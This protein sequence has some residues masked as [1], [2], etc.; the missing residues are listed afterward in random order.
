MTAFYLHKNDV[1]RGTILANLITFLGRLPDTKAWKVEI[2]EHKKSRSPKQRR[3]LFGAAYKPIME[4]MGL[5][6]EEEKEELHYFFCGEY[7]GWREGPMMR[8]RPVRTTTRDENGKRDE[9]TSTVALDFYAFIQQKAL[10]QGIWVPDPD[11]EWRHK[12]DLAPSPEVAH[13]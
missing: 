8:K 3:A 6:G 5:R 7:W 9:I 12:V 4:F 10:E 1:S 2:V 11:P 13:A